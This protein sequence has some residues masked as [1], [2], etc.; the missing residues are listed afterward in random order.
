MKK[1]ILRIVP[2]AE[3]ENLSSL[4]RIRKLLNI[5]KENNK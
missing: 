1:M 3:I 4:G 2:Y 5:T